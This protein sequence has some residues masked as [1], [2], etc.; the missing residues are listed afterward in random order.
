MGSSANINICSKNARVGE[1][2][3]SSA[4]SNGRYGLRI[5]HNVVPRVEVSRDT[6]KTAAKQ[7]QEAPPP[8]LFTCML[9]QKREIFNKTKLTLL[10]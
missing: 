10:F 3:N 8:I 2:R 1:F 6:S 9:L 7:L 5:F 4:D